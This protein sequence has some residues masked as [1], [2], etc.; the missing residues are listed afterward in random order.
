M[1][2][3]FMGF[4]FAIELNNNNNNNCYH[5]ISNDFDKTG[6]EYSLAPT[7]DHN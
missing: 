1:S 5:N 3:V 7:D 4:D 6:R 2:I